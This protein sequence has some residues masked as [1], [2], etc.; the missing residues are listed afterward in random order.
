M[1]NRLDALSIFEIDTP[2]AWKSRHEYM[3]RAYLLHILN[4]VHKMAIVISCMNLY[5]EENKGNRALI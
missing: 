5:I 1:K 4:L 3:Q 2:I